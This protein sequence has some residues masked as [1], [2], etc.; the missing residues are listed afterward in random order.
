MLERILP[1]TRSLHRWELLN[2]SWM[3][4]RWKYLYSSSVGLHIVA[5][6]PIW[7]Y[8]SWFYLLQSGW[9]IE[10]ENLPD[11]VTN[12][13]IFTIWLASTGCQPHTSSIWPW[14]GA[15]K[16]HLYNT[17]LGGLHQMVLLLLR[18]VVLLW[19]C[20]CMWLPY[21]KKDLEANTSMR[22]VSWENHYSW[23]KKIL[24]EETL[25]SCPHT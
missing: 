8:V 6:I 19:Y 18:K 10:S 3:A 1:R 13:G 21:R 16:V 23:T 12:L 17:F 22:R 2:G 14:S 5:L 9:N 25:K 7:R 15:P 4:I 20:F 24:V 11:E